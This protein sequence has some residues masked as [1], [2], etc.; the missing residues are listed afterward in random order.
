M[1]LKVI[2]SQ[3][4]PEFVWGKISG[5]HHCFKLRCFLNSTPHEKID[6]VRKPTK[7][8][9]KGDSHWR[10]YF[11][12]GLF[13]LLH[14]VGLRL[15]VE[16]KHSR[17][18]P[19]F[20]WKK[21]GFPAIFPCN[22]LVSWLQVCWHCTV[23]GFAIRSDPLR[24]AP[25]PGDCAQPAAPLHSWQPPGAPS[26]PP[27]LL[28]R[29]APQPKSWGKKPEVPWKV[30]AIIATPSWIHGTAVVLFNMAQ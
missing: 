5:E 4:F 28:G 25:R 20:M 10:F 19:Y 11:V 29:V 26:Q 30:L 24:P 12:F 18:S 14:W 15:I 21:Y 27:H 3:T 8:L 17:K 13:F 22:P 23:R 6:I 2:V 16:G 7:A 9:E 1:L